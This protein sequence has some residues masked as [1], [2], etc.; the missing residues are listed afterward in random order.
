MIA[1]AVLEPLVPALL[2]PLI[3]ENFS[4][5]SNVNPLKIPILLLAVFCLRVWQNTHQMF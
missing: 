4:Q 3:D 1:V 5:S 2:K